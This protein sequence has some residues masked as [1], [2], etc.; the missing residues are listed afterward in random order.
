LHFAIDSFRI[1]GVMGKGKVFFVGAGPGDIGLVTL[2]GLR[3]LERADVVVY[4]SHVDARLLNRAREDAELIEVGPRDSGDDMTREEI[5]SALVGN[6]KDD[7]VVCRLKEGDPFAFG[8]GGEEAEALLSEGIDFEVVPGVSPVFAAPAGAGIP[9]T[10]RDYSSSFAVV[11]GGEAT[12]KNEGSLS[13]L[14]KACATL[15][16]PIDAGDMGRIID[17]LIDAGKASD[18]PAAV[19]VRGARC[20]Q[21]TVTGSLGTVAGRAEEKG[22]RPPALLVVGNVVSLRERLQ[23]IE[24][25]PLFGH[26]I[27]IT[28]EYSAEYGVLEDLGAE[29]F[30]F[31]TIRIEPPESWEGLDRA[32]EGIAAYQWLVFTSVNG[33]HFFMQQYRRKGLDIR[34]LKGVRLGAI[35]SKT[36]QA[37]RSFGMNVDVVPEAFHAEGLA[38][39]FARLN[40]GGRLEGVRI[41]LPRAEHGREVF[42][43]IVRARGGIIDTPAAYRALKP[44]RGI[45]RLKRSLFEGRISI[46]TFTSSATFLNFIEMVGSDALPF[47]RS[48][49]IAAIGPITRKA[50]EQAGLAVAIMPEEATI[51]AMAAQIVDWVAVAR[52]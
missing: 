17:R 27:L 32:I 23:W 52:S 11:T 40:P 9:L 14:G 44:E 28:R 49:T 7:K 12:T 45:S 4:D 34:D 5:R 47:L 42:P 16:F 36:A 24:K 38:D 35:G 6:A 48:L 46:A 43:E 31:P 51:E 20:D 39:A 37:I 3:C 13:W 29:I 50:I 21:E 30:E 33:F 22:I 41:L 2:K 26:R 8:G 25:K 10:H 15:V 18:T 19:I 1:W